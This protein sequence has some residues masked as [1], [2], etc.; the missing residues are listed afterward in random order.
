[1]S[2]YMPDYDQ[3]G[4]D[5]KQLEDSNEWLQ[6][7]LDEAHAALLGLM[8]LTAAAY[9]HQVHMVPEYV[10]ACKVT[11][12]DATPWEVYFGDLMERRKVDG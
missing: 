8:K 6:A 1:M 12:G 3:L 2:E 9:G 5:V 10:A 7:K 11:R 4:A